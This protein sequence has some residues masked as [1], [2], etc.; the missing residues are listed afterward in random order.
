MLDKSS[1]LKFIDVA[2]SLVTFWEITLPGNLIMRNLINEI[3]KA[4]IMAKQSEV[5]LRASF[6]PDSEEDGCVLSN[7]AF[8]QIIE[9]HTYLDKLLNTVE[10]KP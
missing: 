8:Y 7:L 5:L 6:D 2:R 9:L 3:E 4:K 1:N 10:A